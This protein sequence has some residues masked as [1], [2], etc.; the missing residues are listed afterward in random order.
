MKLSRA[1]IIPAVLLIYLAV[2][3][4]IGYDNY[5]KGGMTPTEYYGIIAL[6]L[7]IIVLL[8]F[9]LKRR[10]RLRRERLADL[11]RKEKESNDNKDITK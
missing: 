11:E 2:M 10:D 4:V 7:V 6:T 8:H 3:A 1:T 5:V 9:S